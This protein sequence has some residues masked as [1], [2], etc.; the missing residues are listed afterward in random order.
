MNQWTNDINPS[1]NG[2]A[3][4]QQD[5]S[6]SFSQPPQ[7]INPAQFQNQP[8][9]NGAVRTGSP[10]FHQ[11]MQYQ[12]NQIIGKRSREDSLGTSPRQA[13]AIPPGSR[14]QTPGQF[15]GYTNGAT[16][17]TSAPTPFQHLQ[18]SN[19]ATPS[20][21]M[22]HMGFQ[23]AQRVSTASPNPFSPQHGIT[24]A[25][26]A[27]S[28]RASRTGTPH[29][30]QQNFMPQQQ[31]FNPQFAQGMGT[32]QQ[33]GMMQQ[34]ALNPTAQYQ[35]QL[36]A[37]MA[38]MTG[39]MQN[40]G[41]SQQ[42][43]VQQM[44]QGQI[45]QQQRMPNS[46]NP[47]DFFAGLQ[48]FSA[49][50]G[51]PFNMRPTIC[52]QPIDVMRL[53]AIIVKAG[54]SQRITKMNQWPQVA[55]M[56]QQF[57]SQQ[58]QQAGTE[59][60]SFWLGSVGA[61]EQMW[62]QQQ[63]KMM[64]EANNRMPNQSPRDGVQNHQ[65]APSDVN[66]KAQTNGMAV[67]EEPQQHRQS[68]SRQYEGN[69]NGIQTDQRPQSGQ[70]LTT[71]AVKVE[72]ESGLS[73][74]RQIPIE[75][76]FIP[77][78]MRVPSEYHGPINVEE[79]YTLGQH[80]IDTK[81][82]LPN[83]REL[84]VVDIHALTMAIKSGM[85]AET[86]NAL[87]TLITLS[88]EPALQLHL[89]W[90]DDLMEALIDYAQ[91]ELDF[92]ADNAAEVSDEI[93]LPA[94]EELVKSCN[95]ESKSLQTIPEFGSLEYDLDRSADKVI[96]ITTLIRNFSFLESNFATISSPE[97]LQFITRV[98]QVIGTKD[99]P[100]R[101]SRNTIDFIKDIIVY[102]SNV[103]SSLYLPTK[104]DALCLLHF[105]LTFAPLP[106][107][108]QNDKI[109]F[110]NYNPAIHKY[111]PPAVDSFAKLLARDEPN[112]VF[113]KA[114]FTADSR[115]P[116]PYELLTRAFGLVV[117][118]VPQS[119]KLV[120]AQIEA[121]KPFLLQGMLAAESLASFAPGSDHP[122]ARSWLQ[123]A[124]CFAGNMLKV[125][126]LLSTSTPN[127]RQIEQQRHAMQQGQRIDEDPLAHG[128]IVNRTMVVL[129]ILVNKSRLVDL[130]GNV[131]T[132]VPG[133]VVMR[134]ETLLAAMIQKDIDVGIL[135]LFCQYAGVDE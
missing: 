94:Y 37:Q 17:Y 92:L 122:L 125:A 30:A 14:S 77:E 60:Q 80:I 127:R 54:Y 7:T 129:K 58:C 47:Q 101:T 117:A 27:P 123:S 66:G 114:I 20:P 63:R 61:F 15:P 4:Q 112:R 51:R 108:H 110:S 91:I 42:Q 23:G 121:R 128:S 88:S 105:L 29:D 11:P 41:M 76:P 85:H 81:P 67:K 52:G 113:F 134:R 32:M 35:L 31:N 106:T 89:D 6:M 109:V 86:R 118:A 53:Y 22:Q 82:V 74:P 64:A 33:M 1:Q 132:D 9:L 84:G 24:G 124:D 79:M 120:A 8:Y 65:R 130:E 25:S 38:A 96:C 49:A 21:T 57:P 131:S 133:H 111:L 18:T 87:D 39:K 102:L 126:S 73:M 99:L 12:T 83:L 93:S 19:N 5:P 45:P 44:V 55:Q 59:L 40:G 70:K 135:R 26:P 43:P 28:D 56:L 3:I 62:V 34:P 116:T 71:S 68:V 75:D 50:K 69:E 2:H 78:V 115:S 46:V 107:P 48:R 95:I 16:P 13:H 100:L 90:C 36:Q 103:S 72:E 119:T 97:V 104:Q 98:I 10:A